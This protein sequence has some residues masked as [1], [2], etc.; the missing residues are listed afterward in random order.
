MSQ[1]DQGPHGLPSLLS[2]LEK[3]NSYI[4]KAIKSVSGKPENE[5]DGYGLKA[6]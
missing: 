6:S 2:H 4:N 5:T 1:E 3:N